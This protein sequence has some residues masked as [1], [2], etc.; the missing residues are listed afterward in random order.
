MTSSSNQKPRGKHLPRSKPALLTKSNPSKK[1][2]ETNQEG[3]GLMRTENIPDTS[4]SSSSSKSSSDDEQSNSSSSESSSDDEQIN[5]SSNTSDVLDLD[6]IEDALNSDDI[7]LNEN[8][9]IEDLGF[10]EDY[11][12]E[13]LNSP[14][15]HVDDVAGVEAH[16]FPN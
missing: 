6:Q 3:R 11:A 14:I 12:L 2:F 9:P 16:S 4:S 15:P 5:S 10:N 7:Q 13:D 8:Y 1:S